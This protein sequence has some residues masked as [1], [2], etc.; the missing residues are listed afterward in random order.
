[1]YVIRWFLLFFFRYLVR[2]AARR[3]LSFFVV[4]FFFVTLSVALPVVSRCSF[5][6]YLV[7]C[8]SRCFLSFYFRYLARW[9]SPYF[10]KKSFFR[11]FVRRPARRFLLFF[12][13]L[14]DS[15]CWP[16][17]AVVCFSFQHKY[18]WHSAGKKERQNST[19]MTT[20]NSPISIYYRTLQPWNTVTKNKIATLL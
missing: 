2:C 18:Y 1:M 10:F 4:F 12:F 3:L 15:L 20:S 13:P 19:T 9:T 16:T 17:V 14:L 8:A 6:H 11:Y 7:R 5:F